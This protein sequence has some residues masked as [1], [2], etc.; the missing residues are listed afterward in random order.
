VK[1]VRVSMWRIKNQIV[2]GRGVHLDFVMSLEGKRG[3]SFGKKR[4]SKLNE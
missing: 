2:I 3:K 4:R 1:E